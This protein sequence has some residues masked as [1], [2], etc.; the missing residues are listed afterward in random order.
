MDEMAGI[1]GERAQIQALQEYIDQM[2]A[3]LPARQ[4]RIVPQHP[5]PQNAP[6]EEDNNHLPPR[7]RHLRLEVA[8]EGAVNA[9][10]AQAQPPAPVRPPPPVLEVAVPVRRHAH[11]PARAAAI[12]KSLTEECYICYEAFD[13]PDSAVWCRR[14][15]GQNIHKECF[16][17]WSGNK[18]RRDVKCGFW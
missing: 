12:R 1:D 10:A 2:L 16:E 15:C 13:G 17:Q 3:Y 9:V 4:E 14:K 8:A 6:V 18:E 7:E 11:R 5:V